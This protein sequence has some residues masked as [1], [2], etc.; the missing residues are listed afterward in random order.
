MAD[1]GSC[2]R[3]RGG[4]SGVECGNEWPGGSCSGR[5]S[6]LA[7]DE[8]QANVGAEKIRASPRMA[9]VAL[10]LETGSKRDFRSW[11]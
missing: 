9:T 1:N 7:C 6:R 11:A 2:G 4:A 3:L 10:I 8:R 5:I